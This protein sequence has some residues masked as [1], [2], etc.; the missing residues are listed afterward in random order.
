MYSESLSQF[1]VENEKE[2]GADAEVR[3]LPQAQIVEKREVQLKR[4]DSKA[5]SQARK[6]VQM[7]EVVNTLT[8]K[9]QKPI[10]YSGQNMNFTPFNSSSKKG[11]VTNRTP[12]ISRNTEGARERTQSGSI[13][14][15]HLKQSEAST[16]R[17]WKD[18]EARADNK[19]VA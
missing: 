5:G 17:R 2:D 12:L 7:Q 13:I 14:R 9:L 4:Y 19:S 16:E 8:L 10:F 18:T 6:Q 11:S 3:G 1:A 15:K